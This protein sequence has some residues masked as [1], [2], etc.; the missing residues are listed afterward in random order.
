MAYWDSS[1]GV[2]V[3]QPP[4][5]IKGYPGWYWVDCG[6]CAGIEWGGEEPRECRE[7]GGSGRVALHATSKRLALYPGGPFCGIA[8]PGE[9]LSV[10]ECRA[11]GDGETK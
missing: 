2:T 3:Y 8:T 6:C 10:E 4:E 1:K 11:P 5:R 9:I 7:C